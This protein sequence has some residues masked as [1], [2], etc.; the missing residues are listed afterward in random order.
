[1]Y[2]YITEELLEAFNFHLNK[3]RYF[4]YGYCKSCTVTKIR[5]I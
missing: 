4:M 3:L 5:K 1:M 2:E